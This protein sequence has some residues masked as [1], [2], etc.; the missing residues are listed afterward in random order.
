MSTLRLAKSHEKSYRNIMAMWWL[1]WRHRPEFYRVSGARSFFDQLKPNS[2]STSP[3]RPLRRVIA[4]TRHTKTVAFAFVPTSSVFSDATVVFALDGS[5]HLAVLQSSIHVAF[6]WQHSSRLK[7][8][9]RYSP[10]DAFE[11][12]PMPEAHWTAGGSTLASLGESYHDLRNEIMRADGLGLTKLYRRFHSPQETDGRT[13][14]LRDLH[15]RIDEA[16]IRAYGWE[17]LKLEHGFHGVAYLPDNDRNRFT[18]SEPAR[19][20]VLHRL[21]ELN[22]RRY[23]EEATVQAKNAHVPRGRG[24]AAP[25]EQGALAL[26]EAPRAPKKKLA[27][28]AKKAGRRRINR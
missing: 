3:P 2:S 23:E 11:T 7:S 27:D 17:D 1:Y 9:L 22:R 14:Q 6:A 28:G 5:A 20:E 16:L 13:S 12:Y 8:D 24:R 19:V 15:R 26:V 18:I 4:I 25:A 21:A 10:T